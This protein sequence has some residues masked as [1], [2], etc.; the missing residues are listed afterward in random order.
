MVMRTFCLEKFRIG[1]FLPGIPDRGR[2][3]MRAEVIRHRP[4]LSGNCMLEV[5]LY[6]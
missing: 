1:V 2:I 3:R 5:A 6:Q 4:V